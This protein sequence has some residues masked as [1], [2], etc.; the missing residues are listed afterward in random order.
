M[1][2]REIMSQ[3]PYSPN[4]EVL[5]KLAAFVLNRESN[6]FRS[7]LYEYLVMTTLN[8]NGEG[9][10][11]G[12]RKKSIISSIERDLSVENLPAVIVSEALDR[13]EAK[14]WI[15]KVRQREDPLYFLTQDEK[16][17]LELIEYY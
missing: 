14:G 15:K 10:T 3:Q 4:T 6:D 2:S 7:E 8:T 9:K 13:L 5:G 11:S 12:I 17:K 16:T 1:Y